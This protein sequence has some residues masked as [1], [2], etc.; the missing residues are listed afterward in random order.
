MLSHDVG[1]GDV[2]VR[3]EELLEA[4]NA[5]PPASALRAT[6]TFDAACLGLTSLLRSASVIFTASG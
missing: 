6:L 1:I 4:A 2:W 3:A 5:A